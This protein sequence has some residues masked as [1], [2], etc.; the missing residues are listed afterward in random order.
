MAVSVLKKELREEFLL[1]RSLISLEEARRRSLLIVDYLL[2]L[3]EFKSAGSV[4]L[5][6]PA[7][8]EVLTD[9]IFKAAS[10]QGKDVYFPK[11]D[12]VDNSI[13]FF[14]VE[15]LEE[16]SPGLYG[17]LEPDGGGDKAKAKDIDLIIVPGV[18]FDHTGMRLGYGKGFYDRELTDVSS[19]KIALAFE[20]QILDEALPCEPHDVKMDM[21]ITE[22]GVERF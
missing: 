19:S 21:L 9:R 16:L 1:K 11:S 17:I 6:S 3:P 13:L 10:T 12:A 18:A 2:G 7:R 5:Y 4:A 8:G 22:R 20:S 15:T 14:K